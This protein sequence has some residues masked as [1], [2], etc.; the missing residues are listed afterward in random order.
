MPGTGIDAFVEVIVIV[1][2]ECLVDTAVEDVYLYGV[3]EA[4]VLSQR[5]HFGAV[6][7]MDI[8]AHI[9][10][11]AVVVERSGSTPYV[12]VVAAVL[13]T[14]VVVAVLQ[15]IAVVPLATGG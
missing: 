11:E 5:H 15:H 8:T 2:G 10:T 1:V 13:V 4:H 14:I 9:H 12:G 7:P 3:H 6:V